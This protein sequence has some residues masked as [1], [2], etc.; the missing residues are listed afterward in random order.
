MKYEAVIEALV[1]ERYEILD[2]IR[3]VGIISLE[4]DGALIRDDGDCV[5][6]V[7]S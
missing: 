4:D 2:C 1:R 5:H 6:E 3:R 7:F